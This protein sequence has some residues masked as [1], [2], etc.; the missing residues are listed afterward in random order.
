MK[1]FVKAKPKARENKIEKID[2]SNFIVSVKAAPIKGKANE[3]IIES[4]AEYFH[5]GN[6]DIE[7]IR[8]HK[9]REKIIEINK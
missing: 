1:I 9:S 6:S 8:G 7:I 5:V 4:L 2:E 3:A